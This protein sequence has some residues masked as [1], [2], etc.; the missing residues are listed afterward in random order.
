MP[1]W[2]CPGESRLWHSKG[3]V[4]MWE[5]IV[6][7]KNKSKTVK[8]AVALVP[9]SLRFFYIFLSNYFKY[10]YYSLSIHLS[11]VFPPSP[12][13]ACHIL[14]SYPRNPECRERG[15]GPTGNCWSCQKSPI[16][17]TL[18]CLF[19]N[20]SSGVSLCPLLFP[21]KSFRRFKV[22]ILKKELAYRIQLYKCLLGSHKPVYEAPRG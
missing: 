20:L 3:Y 22:N 10:L 8:S 5:E 1:R 15:Q 6:A 4:K 17:W 19:P 18:F 12:T 13:L 14:Q 21:L 2:C 16:L 7:N 9:L 11:L